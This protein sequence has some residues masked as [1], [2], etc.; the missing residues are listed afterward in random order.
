MSARALLGGLLASVLL[1][2][3]VYA[4]A[5]HA[6]RLD[7]A[8]AALREPGIWVH[9]DLTWLLSPPQARRLRRTI[10]RAGIPLR[11]AVLPQVETDE[12]RGDPRAIA[13]A[14]IGRVARDGLY[15]L[16]D[17]D[18]RMRSAAR[19]LPLQL[20]D[21]SVDSSIL[22]ERDSLA[23]KLARLASIV[24]A[25]PRAAPRSFEPYADPKGVDRSS[26]GANE[27][28]LALV[29]F[30]SAIFGLM[31]GFVAY[32]LLRMIAAI[33]EHFRKGASA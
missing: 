21:Y 20:G 15:V 9:R 14:I 12:S 18:G 1:A 25:A 26:G 2:G 31:A 7:D 28:P 30:G 29:A 4:D 13:R 24:E 33:V 8:G 27:D 32:C 3:A 17:Q 5:A 6:D 23:A 19:D 22:G 11:V 10:E 16:V